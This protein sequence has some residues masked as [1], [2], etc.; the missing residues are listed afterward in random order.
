MFDI[1]IGGKEILKL[2]SAHY[3]EDSNGE[4]KICVIY[5][6]NK[7]PKNALEIKFEG[8]ARSDSVNIKKEYTFATLMKKF[9]DRRLYFSGAIFLDN[10]FEK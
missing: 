6:I 3:I 7:G 8:F 5:V 1:K 10:Q 2:S 4:K 9:E